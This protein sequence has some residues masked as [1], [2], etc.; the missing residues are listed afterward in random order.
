MKQFN[1]QKIEKII[2]IVLFKADVSEISSLLVQGFVF[3]QNADGFNFLM[4]V[5]LRNS[6]WSNLKEENWYGD[7]K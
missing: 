6:I 4:L 1:I 3:F 7:F 2:F 5:K